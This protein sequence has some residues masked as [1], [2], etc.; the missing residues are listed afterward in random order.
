MPCRAF[1]GMH[2]RYNERVKTANLGPSGADA[3]YSDAA[4]AAQ[5]QQEKEEEEK[6]RE[7]R[8]Q[9]PSHHLMRPSFWSNTTLAPE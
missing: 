7:H 1:E 4:G 6:E 2:A 5:L 8:R 3:R 9:R